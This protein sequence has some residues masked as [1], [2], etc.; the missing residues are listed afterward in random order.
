MSNLVLIHVIGNSP[1]YIQ[2]PM[3]LKFNKWFSETFPSCSTAIFVELGTFLPKNEFNSWNVANWQLFLIALN[4]HMC[5][6]FDN[7]NFLVMH[8]ELSIV[9]QKSTYMNLCVIGFVSYF[10]FLRRNHV[11]L[12]SRPPW[13]TQQ[14]YHIHHIILLQWD[15]S[16]ILMKN[17]KGKNILRGKWKHLTKN[18]S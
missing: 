15:I 16:W 3:Q 10:Y 2:A 9:P 7:G 12:A 17:S 11:A 14:H 4:L 6:E 13:Q 5:F 18:G 8:Y 1:L